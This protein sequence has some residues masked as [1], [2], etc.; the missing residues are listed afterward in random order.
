[1]IGKMTSLGGQLE[2]LRIVRFPRKF[3]ESGCG[4]EMRSSRSSYWRCSLPDHRIEY[5]SC[6]RVSAKF[7]IHDRMYVVN[8]E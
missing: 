2:D 3:A 5:K 8:A 7:I 4:N 1:M 6:H